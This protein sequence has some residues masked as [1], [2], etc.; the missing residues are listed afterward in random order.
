MEP[1]TPGH[2]L[3]PLGA[4]VLVSGLRLLRILPVCAVRFLIC[5]NHPNKF[6]VEF[7]CISVRNLKRNQETALQREVPVVGQAPLKS[8]FGEQDMDVV[9]VLSSVL[10][11]Q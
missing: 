9:N 3:K 10:L 6:G 2:S 11:Q 1:G 7:C 4:A 8:M 5:I